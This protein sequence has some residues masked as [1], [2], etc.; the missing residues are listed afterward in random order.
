MTMPPRPQMN[1]PEVRAVLAEEMAKSLHPML[2]QEAGEGEADLMRYADDVFSVLELD[3]VGGDPAAALV[4]LCMTKPG[5]VAN[6]QVLDVIMKCVLSR[7]TVFQKL[8]LKWAH[9]NGVKIRHQVG[10]VIRG[11]HEG[12]AFE[13]R[14]GHIEHAQAAYLIQMEEGGQPFFVGVEDVT[15]E[16]PM[17]EPEPVEIV[18]MQS[19]SEEKLLEQGDQES[20]PALGDG[21]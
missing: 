20:L 7:A 15:G 10:Q 14:I 19:F 11:E 17:P 3:H 13:G 6:M 4:E 12:Q 16:D 2:D 5:W 9:D 1:G 18:E 8:G 21:E